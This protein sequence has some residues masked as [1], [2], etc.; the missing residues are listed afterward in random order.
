MNRKANAQRDRAANGAA[1]RLLRPDV[2]RYSEPGWFEEDA[3]IVARALLRKKRR[4]ARK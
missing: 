2:Y 1:R 4:K 3:R